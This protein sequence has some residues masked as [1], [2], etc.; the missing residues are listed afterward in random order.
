MKI[1]LLD[2]SDGFT[3]ADINDLSLFLS[4]SGAGISHSS[5]WTDY[6]YNPQQFTRYD[7]TTSFLRNS[8]LKVTQG[9]FLS[10]FLPLSYASSIQPSVHKLLI[11]YADVA[12][13]GLLYSRNSSFS[14]DQN[15]IMEFLELSIEKDL[16]LNPRKYLKN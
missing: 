8:A 3:Y 2:Y 4:H 5:L 11:Q 1:C 10:P 13:L 14:R 15:I 12:L 16:S 6:F 9:A 7:F